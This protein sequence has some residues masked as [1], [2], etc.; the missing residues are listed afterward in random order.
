MDVPQEIQPEDIARRY[1]QRIQ[2][3]DTARRS[4]DLTAFLFK[5]QDEVLAP[6]RPAKKPIP[7]TVDLEMLKPPR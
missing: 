4:I 7:E 1:N 6:V 2:P 3:E 5:N